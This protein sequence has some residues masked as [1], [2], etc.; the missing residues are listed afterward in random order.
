MRRGASGTGLA[1]ANCSTLSAPVHSYHFSIYSH[2]YHYNLSQVIPSR[3][4]SA[5]E[6]Y[7]NVSGGS[8][9]STAAV[10]GASLGNSLALHSNIAGWNFGLKLSKKWTPDTKLILIVGSRSAA[11]SPVGGASG[12]SSNLSINKEESGQQGSPNR[13]S[14][15]R[16]SNEAWVCPNDRQLALRAK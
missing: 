8:G 3:R 12:L 5:V 11:T 1:P 16:T 2:I 14:N 4:S 9:N 15:Q 13:H 10:Q 7:S 6:L